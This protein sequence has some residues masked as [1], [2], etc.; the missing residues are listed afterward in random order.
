[1]K[2]GG[3]GA[4]LVRLCSLEHQAFVEDVSKEL[5]YPLPDCAK[6]EAT[7]DGGI[8]ATQVSGLG[9]VRT[10]EIDGEGHVKFSLLCSAT[11]MSCTSLNRKV[12]SDPLSVD[13]VRKARELILKSK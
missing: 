2:A 5:D 13:K 10:V 9:N 12:V 11:D 7:K 6:L 8:K 1:M 4:N 3:D